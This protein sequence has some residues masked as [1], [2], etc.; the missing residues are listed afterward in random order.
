MACLSSKTVL[1][2][3]IEIWTLSSLGPM[4]GFPI[5]AMHKDL[6]C[7][8]IVPFTLIWIS[9]VTPSVVAIVVEMVVRSKPCLGLL[10]STVVIPSLL[11]NDNDSEANGQ[12]CF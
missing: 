10:F 12:A 11:A 1:S 7:Q 3:V 9:G 5:S 2:V 8:K 4:I 6:W